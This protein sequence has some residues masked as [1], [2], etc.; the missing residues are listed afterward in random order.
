MINYRRNYPIKRERT[1]SKPVYKSVE[2]IPL[3]NESEEVRLISE[4]E[5]RGLTKSGKLLGVIGLEELIL[6]GLIFLLI[7]EGVNDDF[8]FILLIYILLT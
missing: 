4:T 6:I 8:L 2:D 5:S 7:N 1:Y 3:P